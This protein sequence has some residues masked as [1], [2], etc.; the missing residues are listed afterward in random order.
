MRRYYA[1]KKDTFDGLITQSGLLLKNLDIEAVMNGEPGYTDDDIICATSG[2]IQINDSTEWEDLAEDV[3]NAPVNMKEFK[4]MTSRSSSIST[5]ALSMT[6]ETLRMALGAAD[7]DESGTMVV[8]R[9]ELNYDKDFQTIYW[10]SDMANDGAVVAVLTNAL[11]TGG[12]TVQT[13]KSTKATLSI[14]LTGHISI[15]A[16]DVAPLTFYVLKPVEEKS[17]V[18]LE[19]ESAST[20]IF[21]TPVSDIQSNVAVKNNAI[22]GTLHYLDSGDLVDT[23]GEG[24]FLALKFTDIA[25]DATSVKVGLEPSE[26]SGLVEIIDDP[27]KNGAFKITDKNTQKFK[28]VTTIAGETVEQTF[29]LSGLTVESE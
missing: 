23:W 22:T 2:G 18:T 9:T 24:N 4:I 15:N 10:A 21:G 20:V 28:I 11:S 29:D 26:G 25:E 13:G 12:M 27:D 17:V 14:E 8:P 5:T 16:Q 7:I 19:P 6:P 1:V 3:D